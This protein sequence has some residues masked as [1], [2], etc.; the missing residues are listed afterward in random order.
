MGGL[1]CRSPCGDDG[2]QLRDRHGSHHFHPVSAVARPPRRDGPRC[3][4]VGVDCAV[5]DTDDHDGLAAAA[6]GCDLLY[7]ETSTIATV[8]PLPRCWDAVVSLYAD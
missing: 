3:L 8:W 7:L 6:G 2:D 1:S 5:L 4:R